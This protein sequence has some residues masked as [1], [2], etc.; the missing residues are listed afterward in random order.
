VGIPRFRGVI[1]KYFPTPRASRGAASAFKAD[2]VTFL[3]C[4][5]DEQDVFIDSDSVES[6]KIRERANRKI[7]TDVGRG[8]RRRYI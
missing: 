8:R 1:E 5:R 4:A 3:A 2:A 6:K 7:A